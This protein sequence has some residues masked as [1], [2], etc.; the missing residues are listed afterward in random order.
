MP[1]YGRVTLK[2]SDKTANGLTRCIIDFIR[3]TGGQ[4]E[5]VNCTGRVID[6]REIYTDVLG[7]RRIV[8]S[9]AFI[10]TSGQRG[11]ADISA[12]VKGRSIKIEVKVGRD[13]QRPE[14]VEY[15]RQIE[16]SGGLYVIAKDF[17]QFFIWYRQTWG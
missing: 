6:R 16:A 11:T 15:Q 3:L 14:Q 1:E 10:K 8:G 7:H 5:R 4:A 12:T 17:E 2:Y 9:L 13:K